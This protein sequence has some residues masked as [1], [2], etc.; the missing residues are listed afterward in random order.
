MMK[1]DRYRKKEILKWRVWAT[2]WCV[3]FILLLIACIVLGIISRN[4]TSPF[5][6]FIKEITDV[7]LAV[8][9]IP[10]ILSIVNYFTGMHCYNC[11]FN[12][13]FISAKIDAIEFPEDIREIDIDEF[14]KQNKAQNR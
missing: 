11:W 14:R 10:V 6:V 4:N 7:K 12:P 2:V 1:R 8:L 3:L 9:T 13:T 5:F